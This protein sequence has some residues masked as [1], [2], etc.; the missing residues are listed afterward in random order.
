VGVATG[1]FQYANGSPVAN[2]LYQFKL[3]GDAILSGSACVSP[4]LI[5]GYLDTN[6]SLSATFAF[7][8]ALSTTATTTYQLTVKAPTGEQVWNERYTLTGTAAN[9]NLIVPSG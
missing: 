1:T 6:G 2:G 4:L 5:T 7:N 9:L 3:S 8:D